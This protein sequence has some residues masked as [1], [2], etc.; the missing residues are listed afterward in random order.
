M[1]PTLANHAFVFTNQLAHTCQTRHP[2]RR[3]PVER[4]GM[5]VGMGVGVREPC[6]AL[7]L[8][9]PQMCGSRG[10]AVEDVCRCLSWVSSLDS[11]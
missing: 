6:T 1:L 3:L 2:Q 7:I 8:T 9:S 5:L 10:G 4:C 11:T